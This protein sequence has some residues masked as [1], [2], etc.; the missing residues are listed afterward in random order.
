MPRQEK[1]LPLELA[2]LR[3][4]FFLYQRVECGHGGNT[5]AAYKRDL[6]D[7]LCDLAD[8]G[9]STSSH[10]TPQ[11]LIGHMQ[12]LT[13]ERKLASSTVTRHLSTIRIF[14][15]WMVATGRLAANPADHLDRP[16]KWRRLPKTLSPGE[17]RRLVTA[18][19]PEGTPVEGKPQ[20]WLRDRAI[21]ELMY[22]SGLR[23]SEVGTA[24]LAGYRPDERHILL[25]GKGR[26]YRTVPIGEPAR[27]AVDAYLK[28][29][30]PLLA[31]MTGEDQGCLFLSSKG[32]PLHR[33]SVWLIV[34]KWAKAAGLGHVHPHMLRHSF[35]THLL[36]G[37]ADLRVVQELL[38]HADLTTTEIYTHVD[39]SRF[40]AMH[41]KFHPR[42]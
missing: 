21:L 8:H 20:L 39:R 6:R 33:A 23:A 11:A 24:K 25:Y 7:L 10:I 40:K 28:H 18:P 31:P 36:Q 16:H 3:D 37:G 17:M 30:R 34:G 14:C 9:V 19:A 41:R 26:K 15:K 2:D 12:R 42:G 5:L 38:G 4:D 35:A 22:A 13:S 1:K 29:V 27:K 32:F